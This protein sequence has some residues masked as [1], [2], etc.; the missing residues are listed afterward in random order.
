MTP[1]S[2]AE[3]FNETL[4]AMKSIG[5]SEDEIESIFGIV[6]AVLHLSNIE[7]DSEDEEQ[8]EIVD[9]EAIRALQ[10]AAGLLGCDQ[11]RLR[12]ALTSRTIQTKGN[13]FK[14]SDSPG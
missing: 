1:E 14:S 3:Q 12:F 13:S 9:L 5:M 4:N 7:F 6:A 10:T 8:A 11:T 2:E